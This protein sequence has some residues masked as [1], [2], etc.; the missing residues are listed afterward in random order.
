MFLRHSNGHVVYPG[1]TPAHLRTNPSLR[2]ATGLGNFEFKTINPQKG[3]GNGRKRWQCHRERHASQS[4]VALGTAR[5]DAAFC[6]IT[7]NFP[8]CGGS[9]VEGSNA[10]AFCRG[11]FSCPPGTPEALTEGLFGK[12]GLKAEHLSV[13]GGLRKE[14]LAVVTVLLCLMTTFSTCRSVRL[15]WTM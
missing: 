15:H 8:G 7:G 14:M 13:L 1:P 10:A 6:M 9:P 5:A 2:R 12:A 3:A 11:A 4:A